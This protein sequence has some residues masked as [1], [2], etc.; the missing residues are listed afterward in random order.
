MLNS[1]IKRIVV[2]IVCRKTNLYTDANTSVYF[3]ITRINRASFRLMHRLKV[4]RR[5][6][7]GRGIIFNV[8]KLATEPRSKRGTKFLRGESL[9]TENPVLL[10]RGN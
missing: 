3:N 9:E 8:V 1:I 10:R 4:T 6:K 5:V 7:F 2:G